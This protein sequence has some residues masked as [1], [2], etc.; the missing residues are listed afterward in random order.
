MTISIFLLEMLAEAEV[1]VPTSLF[2]RPDLQKIRTEKIQVYF[3]FLLL[4]YS[5]SLSL[6]SPAF[7][8]AAI[9]IRM[10][11]SSLNN[12]GDCQRTAK[13]RMLRLGENSIKQ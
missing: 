8:S 5:P 3:A 7:P 2:K 13:F 4:V 11:L 6:Y 1:L 12:D 9:I 10:F